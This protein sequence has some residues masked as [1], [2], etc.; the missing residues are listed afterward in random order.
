MSLNNFSLNIVSRVRQI[1]EFI[2]RQIRCSR[3]LVLLGRDASGAGPAQEITIGAGLTLTGTTL[4]ADGVGEITTGLQAETAARIAGDQSLS[5]AL[6]NEVQARIAGDAAILREFAAGDPNGGFGTSASAEITLTGEPL[7]GQSIIIGGESYVFNLGPAPYA[8]TEIS[9][10]NNPFAPVAEAWAAGLTARINL[11]RDGGS[12]ANVTAT[13][14][15]SVVT[16]TAKTAGTSGNS[17]TL[18]ENVSNLTIS[19]ASLSGGVN[20]VGDPLTGQF[21]GQQLRWEQATAGVFKWY[22]WNGTVWSEL[23][24]A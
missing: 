6:S 13:R 16:I 8:P 24:L 14:S 19:G 5:T 22:I 4:S 1:Q 15:G 9:D 17:I 12:D 18:S 10:P 2:V 20:G 3:G 7:N 21:I 11:W 23:A